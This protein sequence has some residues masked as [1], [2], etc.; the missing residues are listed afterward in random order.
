MPP[1]NPDIK[2]I[3]DRAYHFISPTVAA[4]ADMTFEELRQFISGTSTPPADKL[5]R[6]VRRMGLR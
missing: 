2:S 4:D 1:V 3:R 5:D 6:L